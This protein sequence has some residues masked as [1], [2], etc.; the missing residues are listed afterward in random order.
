MVE[1]SNGGRQ[2]GTTRHLSEQRIGGVAVHRNPLKLRLALS[3]PPPPPLSLQT[4]AIFNSVLQASWS[5]SVVWVRL[6]RAA[7][8]I[9]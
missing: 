1:G 4:V 2:D 9:G 7:L 6:A 8:L 5:W 3:L